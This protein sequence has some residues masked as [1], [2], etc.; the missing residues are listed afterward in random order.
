ML[1]FTLLL[2]LGVLVMMTEVSDITRSKD[3]IKI[4][5]L[6]HERYTAEQAGRGDLCVV[7]MRRVEGGLKPQ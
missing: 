1:G 4:L 6:V 5:R 7:R 3:V 2:S